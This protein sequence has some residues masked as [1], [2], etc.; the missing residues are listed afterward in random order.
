M[1]YRSFALAVFALISFSALIPVSKAQSRSG[2]EQPTLQ[3][4]NSN[5]ASSWDAAIGTIVSYEQPVMPLGPVDVLREYE[6]E[7]ARVAARLYA[8]LARI[9]QAKRTNQI[10]RAQAEYLIAERYQIAI[11]QYQV[12]SALHESLET[13]LGSSL[14]MVSG[15]L[16]I[17]PAI[18][19]Q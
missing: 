18:L 11:M 2:N 5:A 9:T 15:V 8:D 19:V 3:K 7:M 1:R 13:D 6:E 14:D 16:N 12:L 4:A 10:T 17:S